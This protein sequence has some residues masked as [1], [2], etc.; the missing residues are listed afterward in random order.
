MKT[1]TTIH[2]I[3]RHVSNQCNLGQQDA[4]QVAGIQMQARKPR[5]GAGS[6]STAHT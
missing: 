4:W 2:D 5:F 1:L 3:Y 6:H